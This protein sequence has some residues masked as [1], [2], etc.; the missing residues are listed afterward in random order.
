M[1]HI[2]VLRSFLLRRLHQQTEQHNNLSHDILNCIVNKTCTGWGGVPPNAVGEI[3]NM[4]WFLWVLLHDAKH[5]VMSGQ[6][7]G[8]LNLPVL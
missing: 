5:N 2:H 1:E 6:C 8:G 4:S 3:A 7:L